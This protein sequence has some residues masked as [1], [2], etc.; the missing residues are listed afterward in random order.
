MRNT[1]SN[2][3]K[4]QVGQTSVEIIPQI[5]NFVKR[6]TKRNQSGD[7]PQGTRFNNHYPPDSAI[8]ITQLLEFVNTKFQSVKKNA[9][10][11]DFSERLAFLFYKKEVSCIT[12]EDYG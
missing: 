1:S 4:T 9:N 10:Y 7:Y 8:S 11:S 5:P 6:T 3:S 12:A 2:T